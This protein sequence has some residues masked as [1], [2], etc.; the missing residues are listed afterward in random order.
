MKGDVLIMAKTN[1]NM[2]LTD[3]E[4]EIM[5]FV[6]EVIFQEYNSSK[7]DVVSMLFKR[8]ALNYLGM[9]DDDWCSIS[10]EMLLTMLKSHKRCED[11]RIISI[12]GAEKYKA[13]I[14]DYKKEYPKEDSAYMEGLLEDYLKKGDK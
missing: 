12:I 10:D 14:E 5:D 2:Q 3:T 8:T 11:M 6:T 7:A 9:N 13:L 4:K 1:F